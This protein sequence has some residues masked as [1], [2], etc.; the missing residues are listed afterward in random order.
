MLKE[1][2]PGPAPARPLKVAILVTPEIGTASAFA[3][4]HILGSVGTFWQSLHGQEGAACFNPK[5]VSADGK[6]FADSHGITITPHGAMTDLA[7]PD[8][9]IIPEAVFEPWLGYPASWNVITDWVRQSYAEGAIVAS[10]CSG[11][12]LLAETGLLDGEDATAHWAYADGVA[13][14]HPGIRM[15][16]DRVLVLA[17][18]DERLIT[19][20]GFSSW[21]DLLL[22]LVRRLVSPAESRRMAK[23][24]LLDWHTDGQKPFAALTVGRRHEDPV[25]SAAQVW[26]ADNYASPNPVQSMA[27]Q[28][29]LTERSFLRRFKKAT[30]QA[31]LEYIQ[32]LR[33]EEAKQM[34]ETTELGF[35]D[36]AAEVGYTEPSAFRH[37]F[38][39]LV[40]ITPSSY[41]ARS[42]SGALVD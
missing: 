10:I 22:Y 35:D 3:V 14:R 12:L 34:L 42:Q 2:T 32:T 31:P 4:L 6:P 41:R 24:F 40:G 26:A 7:Q 19:T 16:P 9:I 33:I 17:G 13:L 36:I 11:T 28:S 39:K 20:G 5:L 21:H 8:V 23:L 27:A 30:G 38:R 18:E 29:G 37:L 15:R 1:P 25:V